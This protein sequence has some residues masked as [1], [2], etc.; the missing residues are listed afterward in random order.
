MSITGT[1]VSENIVIPAQ[2]P[3]SQPVSQPQPQLQL[4][5]QPQQPPTLPPH[6]N[7]SIAETSS[8]HHTKSLSRK[9]PPPSAMAPRMQQSSISSPPIQPQSQQI[10]QSQ[11]QIQHQ[12]PLPHSIIPPHAPPPLQTP[13]APVRPPTLEKLPPGTL[14]TVGSHQVKIVKYLSEGGYAHIYAVKIN[15]LEDGKDIAC[16]K[17]VIVPNKDGLN[18][19]RAEVEVMQRLCKFDNIVKYYDSNASRMINSPGCYEVLVLMEL[20]PNKSLLDF[21]NSRL[22]TKLTI[23]E[24]LKIMMDISK[25]VYSMH[26]L[27]LI[28]RDIKIENVLLD[29]HFNFKLADFG[30]T[31]P[32]LRVPR[33]QQ[34]FQILHNDILLQTTPQYRSPEMIDLYRGLPI[35]DKSDIW[36][37]GVFLYKLC[38]YITPFE[39]AGELSILH[40]AYSFPVQPNFPSNLKNL[41]NLMLQENPMFRPN[42]YQVLIELGKILNFNEQLYKE[43]LFDQGYIDF[44]GVGEY[45]YP[46]NEQVHPPIEPLPADYRRCFFQSKNSLG[47]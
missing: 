18:Q 7:S 34:E 5:Q 45:K 39:I 4:Q 27:K 33:N 9:P 14:L 41:I 10:S 25:A 6:R 29:E 22:R 11:P 19:L 43:V 35:D 28:H 12:Q 21:M 30:S 44:Y 1:S 2:Q 40:A 37:L 24:I 32:I 15:P 3:V 17:R 47:R 46:S 23:N 16:L 31:C 36:A 42:I 26:K 13:P 8:L 20:C 38:Y